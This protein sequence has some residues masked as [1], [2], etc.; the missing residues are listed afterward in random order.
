MP[1]VLA[2]AGGQGLISYLSW[3]TAPSRVRRHS[4]RTSPEASGRLTLVVLSAVLT[5]AVQRRT[6]AAPEPPVAASVGRSM[7]SAARLSSSSANVIEELVD[8][9]RLSAEA[10]IQRAR[11]VVAEHVLMAHSWHS[12]LQRRPQITPFLAETRR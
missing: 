6:S 11:D 7:R 12:V 5:S 2:S 3:V 9:P 4:A 1:S 8:E 10:Q